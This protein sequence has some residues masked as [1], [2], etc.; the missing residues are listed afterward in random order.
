MK[1]D[2]IKNAFDSIDIT[3]NSFVT[4][5]LMIT[6]QIFALLEEKG[7]SQRTLAKKLETQPSDVS[8]MLSGLQN[9]TLRR[10]TDLEAIFET[11][12][13]LTPQKIQEQ[14][15]QN[16]TLSKVTDIP[17][18]IKKFAPTRWNKPTGKD[19]KIA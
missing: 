14:F 11:D 9:I 8:R 13:I 7:W 18:I 16:H 12:I 3:S 1:K 2:I 6:E 15:S 19:K 4:K 10:I 5:N 17:L